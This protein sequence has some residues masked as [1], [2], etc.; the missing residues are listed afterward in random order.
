SFAGAWAWP[1]IALLAWPG[2]AQRSLHDHVRP[3]AEAL[4]QHDLPAARAAVGM[5]VGR[6]TAA[7]DEA[8]VARAAI[9]SLAESFCDGVV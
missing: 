1:L 7:L 6:D 5:V 2:L 8:A 4:E 9:E 3:V